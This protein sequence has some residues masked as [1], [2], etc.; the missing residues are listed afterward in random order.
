M[1]SIFLGFIILLLI[2]GAIF[3]F[4]TATLYLPHYYIVFFHLNIGYLHE[5]Y[6]YLRFFLSWL[7][8]VIDIFLIIAVFC[9][10]IIDIFEPANFLRIWL[11]KD[12]LNIFFDSM[13]RYF[14]MFIPRIFFGFLKWFFSCFVIAIFQLQLVE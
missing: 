3:I 13:L 4:S 5:F 1:N 6:G 14:S 11:D 7:W 10:V 9:L 8:L 12:Y 2:F